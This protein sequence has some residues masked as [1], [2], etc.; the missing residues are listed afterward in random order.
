MIREGVI[1]LPSRIVQDRYL[2]AIMNL[3]AA[4]NIASISVIKLLHLV[5]N[6]ARYRHVH[7]DDQGSCPVTPQASVPIGARLFRYGEDGQDVLA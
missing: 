3:T 7:A 4:Y 6:T 1:Q 2:V 5:N